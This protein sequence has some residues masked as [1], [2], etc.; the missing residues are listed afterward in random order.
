MLDANLVHA[1][2]LDLD[3][4]LWPVWPAIERAE[5][6][7]HTWLGV[8]APR[9]AALFADVQALRDIRQQV[10]ANRPDLA[11]DLSALR[12]ESIRQA[13]TQAG[14]D[15]ALAD[16][17]FDV[18]FRERQ[19]V[20]F[21]EGALGCLEALAARYPI[22]ALTNGNADVHLIGIGHH[23]QASITARAF[24]V[25][26]P[27]A[28]I[29]LAAAEALGTPPAHVLHVGDDAALDAQGA[30]DAGMQAA[31][32]NRGGHPWP[33]AGRPHADVKDLAQLCG[34]LRVPRGT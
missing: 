34:L 28:R 27:D 3:D 25:A 5:A 2:T 33:H 26:K 4:T 13:I 19:R 10:G 20:E 12:R 16:E 32:L 29:F 1:I 8:H 14:E 7:L 18:F 31:W 21:F 24:G 30:I 17:A 6:A 22:A 11:H 15:S 9:T 23:F